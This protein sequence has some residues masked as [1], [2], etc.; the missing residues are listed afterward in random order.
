M[1]NNMSIKSKFKNYNVQ[2]VDDLESV[3]VLAKCKET[4]FVIDKIVY[5]LYK[6]QLPQFPKERLYLLDALESK[7][8]YVYCT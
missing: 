1:S 2:F 7:K 3:I 4:F 5:N 8:K 6:N